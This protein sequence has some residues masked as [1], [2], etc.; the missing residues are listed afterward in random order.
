MATGVA[1][2]VGA[3]PEGALAGRAIVVTRP[4]AQAEGLSALIRA[5]GGTPVC[6]PTIDIEPLPQTTELAA[7]LAG[8]SEI[9]LAVFISANAV[10]CSLSH[11]SAA[12]PAGLPAAAIGPGTAAA[13][14][15]R[16]VAH[17]IVP[18]V[19]F[20]SEGLLKAIGER[21]LAPRRV[22]LF[23]GEGGREWLADALREG[24]AQVNAVDCYRRVR[25][26]ADARIIGALAE[27]GEL[28]GVVVS[29][30]QGADHLFA[31]LGA[32]GLAW[33]DGVPVF[34]PHAR[35]AGRVAAHGAGTVVQTAGGDAGLMAG[36]AAH[37]SVGRQWAT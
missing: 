13:L 7:A 35:I 11:L 26:P 21:G 16:G 30:S 22:T 31:L 27:R 10:A 24:G 18:P 29:S 37:F 15:G 1:A 14:A 23:K 25:A 4:Q 19:Q 32:D 2:T 28:A 3:T 33:L 6:F 8:L 5:A 12:W 17:V 9:D 34:V 20:D 36:M